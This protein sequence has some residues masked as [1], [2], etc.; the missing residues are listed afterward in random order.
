VRRLIALAPERPEPYETLAEALLASGEPADAVRVALQQQW[1]RLPPASRPTARASGEADLAVAAGDFVAAERAYEELDRLTASLLD[2]D[3]KFGLAYPRV[4]IALETGRLAEARRV[5]RAYL[6]QRPGFTATGYDDS[7][8]MEAAS[9]AS[10]EITRPQFDEVRAAWLSRNPDADPLRR[11][12]SAY[13]LPVATR[14]DA[15]VA[16]AKK[17]DLPVPTSTNYQAPSLVEPMGRA[18]FLAGK[19]DEGIAYLTKASTSCNQ[20]RAVQAIFSLWA[21]LELGHARERRGD[22]AGACTAYRRVLARW[23]KASPASKSAAEALA[24]TRA[25]GCGP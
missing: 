20:L 15:E 11:W 17:P 25:V 6:R 14:E 4:L 23:G 3:T 13:A 24:R 7:L 21:T 9:L 22:V 2:D 8:T 16:L 18:S 10:G 5:A 19:V 12:I 1:D